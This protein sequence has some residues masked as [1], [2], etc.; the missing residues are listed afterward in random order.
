MLQYTLT[1]QYFLWFQKKSTLFNDLLDTMTLIDSNIKTTYWKRIRNL[2]TA[3]N[4]LSSFKLKREKKLFPF[5][6]VFIK[7]KYWLDRWWFECLHK[8]VE[9]VAIYKNVYQQNEWNPYSE[10]SI[11]ITMFFFCYYFMFKM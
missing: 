6:F 3:T 10:T 9:S 1:Q 11:V 5:T 8:F 7:K 2:C 4:S